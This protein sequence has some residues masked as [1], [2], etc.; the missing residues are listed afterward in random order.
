M[1][2]IFGGRLV[3]DLEPTG[4]RVVER[5]VQCDRPAPARA[6][7][8]HA[9][10]RVDFALMTDAPS[11]ESGLVQRL[12]ED[13][14]AHYPPAHAAALSGGRVR[15]ILIVGLSSSGFRCVA[16]HRISHAARARLGWPGRLFSRM[17]YWVGRHWYG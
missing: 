16:I 12:Y 1:R 7:G 14:V 2:R 6:R 4:A 9:D 10:D 13:A 5:A 15:R 17:L 11:S 3:A 8:G